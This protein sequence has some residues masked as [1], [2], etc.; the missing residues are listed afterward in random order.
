[1]NTRVSESIRCANSRAIARR[2]T[3]RR[4]YAVVVKGIRQLKSQKKEKPHDPI[5]A[6]QLRSI[7]Q[8]A[9][10]MMFERNHHIRFDLVNTA[11]PY[12]KLH[13]E[14]AA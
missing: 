14:Q 10:D 3:W 8:L 2:D 13:I 6:A 11:Y 5:V 4:Q 7:R 9:C 12:A 1:M